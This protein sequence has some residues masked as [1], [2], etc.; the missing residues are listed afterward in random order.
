MAYTYNKFLLISNQIIPDETYDV[1]LKNL[2][3]CWVGW[4]LAVE[5]ARI[6]DIREFQLQRILTA[7]AA[8]SVN[9]KSF[10]LFNWSNL[11]NKPPISTYF[12]ETINLN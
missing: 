12:T 2:A 10:Q 3:D 6:W 7:S 1:E 9:G 5:E 11:V 4:N 8:E